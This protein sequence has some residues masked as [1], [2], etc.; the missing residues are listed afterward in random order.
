MNAASTESREAMGRQIADEA[1]AF[2]GH[3]GLGDEFTEWVLTR[4]AEV[5]WLLDLPLATLNQQPTR[6][7]RD[8]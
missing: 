2:I 6:G 3:K 1:H 4:R 7:E 8:A 5:D